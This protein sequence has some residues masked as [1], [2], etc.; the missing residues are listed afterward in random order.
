M[1]AKIKTGIAGG[2]C[3]V[4]VIIGLVLDNGHVRTN[5]R[6]LELIGNAEGCRRDPYNCPAGILTD[7]IG[8]THGVKPGNRKT[9]EQI[10]ADWEK[11]ILDAEQ[12]V[13]RYANGLDLS[14]NA[15]SASVSLTFRTGCGNMRT[16]TLFSL[17]RS[18]QVK[19]A[20][21]QFTRWV[22]GGGRILPGLVNRADKEEALC[23]DGL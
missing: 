18:G 7:G 3:S 4:A 17:L 21:G 6:G 8:N 11:N 16:S 15:F 12:C 23:L 19:A 2:I 22:W 5:Q 1:S 14:D 10:A 20:C 13:N 9:D